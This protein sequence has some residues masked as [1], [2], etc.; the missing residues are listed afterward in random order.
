MV[1][2]CGTSPVY[3]VCLVHLVDLVCFVYLFDLAHLVSFV[4][5]NKQD[6]PNKP[7]EQGR[8][9]DFFSIL[10]KKKTGCTRVRK[11]C[12]MRPMKDLHHRDLA[13]MIHERF[14]C[15]RL[16]VRET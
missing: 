14:C 6:K 7:N 13:R 15:N 16:P 4:Q 1:C 2:T 11:I 8:L 3:L 12:R 9:A 10:L 5:P